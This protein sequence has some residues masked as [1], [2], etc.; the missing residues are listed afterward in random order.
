MT[1]ERK[2][3]P[4]WLDTLPPDE[5]EARQSRRDL[6][7]INRAMGNSGWFLRNLPPLLRKGERVLEL[8]AGEG[9]LGRRL[10][11]AGLE[12]DGLDRMPRPSG[13]TGRWHQADIR[14]F[15][16]FWEYGALVANLVLH[17]FSAA[18]L[19]ELGSRLS[20]GPRLILASEPARRLR[21][22]RVFILLGLAL[23]LNRVTDHDGRISIG[24]GFLGDE[25]PRALGLGPDRWS[26][27]CLE[28]LSGASRM[29]AIRTP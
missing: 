20:G 27:R 9:E 25:L 3:E 15:E 1:L 6:R 22:L 26:L 11:A 13:W 21:N 29:I 24:A 7:W 2:L 4:E 5:P 17:H 19:A 8:G 23:R 14:E 10:S 16:G 28:S 12:V 18:E